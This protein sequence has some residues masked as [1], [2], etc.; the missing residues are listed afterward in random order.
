MQQVV[1]SVTASGTTGSASGT[2][3]AA[4]WYSG[5]L[6]A[7][8]FDTTATTAGTYLR[9]MQDYSPGVTLLS[10]NSTADGWYFPRN[11]L[12][13]DAG[14]AAAANTAG[15]YPVTGYLAFGVGSS[16]PTTH[17]AYV[18]IEEQ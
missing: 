3:T 11:E 15:A 14:T 17:V 7:V 1:L 8:Y 16:V 5:K 12:H 9:I 18:Y 13:T 4:V 6:H 10:V 2:T